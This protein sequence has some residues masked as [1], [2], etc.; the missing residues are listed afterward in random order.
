MNR[1]KKRMNLSLLDILDRLN[2]LEHRV[3]LLE[4]ENA[5]LKNGMVLKR[6]IDVL[7]WLNNEFDVIPK[8]IQLV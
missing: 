2:H 4:K 7:D 8:Q 1:K 3:N 5:S 6:K